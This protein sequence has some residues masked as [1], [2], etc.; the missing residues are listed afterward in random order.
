MMHLA[1]CCKGQEA[2]YFPPY[3]FTAVL[4]KQDA[5]VT[6]GYSTVEIESV[7]IYETVRF[8]GRLLY[9]L[10]GSGFLPL[11]SKTQNV[12]LLQLAVDTLLFHSFSRVINV[13]NKA[14][15]CLGSKGRLKRKSANHSQQS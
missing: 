10:R 9:S 2:L 14:G 7:V 11:L 6:L 3:D 1:L 15:L 4:D 5:A 8:L 12:P 13:C